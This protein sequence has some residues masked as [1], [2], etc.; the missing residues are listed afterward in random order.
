MSNNNDQIFQLSLT[1][2]AF[3]L[4]FILMFLLGTMIFLA[5]KEN[6]DLKADLRNLENFEKKKEDLDKV[7]KLVEE[8]L[9]D[10]N[11]RNPDEVIKNLV[12]SARAQEEIV[13][14][15]KL[16]NEQDAKITTLSEIQKAIDTT[17]GQG[18][19]ALVQE[20]I[21]KAL[22]L[23]KELKEQLQAR[24][25]K[26]EEI[27]LLEDIDRVAEQT[28]KLFVWLRTNYPW[29]SAREYST[30]D[31]ISDYVIANKHGDCGQLSLLFITLC[32]YNGIPARWQS[33]FML[34][35][36]G[37]NLHDWAEIY[38]E[39]IGWIPVD[40][41]FGL[42]AWGKNDD[43][44]LFFFGG[45]DAYHLTINNDFGRPLSPEK[46]HLRSETVDFQRGEVEWRGGNLY[47]D[48]W[49]YAFTVAPSPPSTH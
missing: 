13:K 33:G 20:R 35:P 40:S 31:H 19:G 17:K 18:D 9:V 30:I 49:D 16:I 4:V 47:F 14:L 37:K 3:I 32:R 11:V 23:S 26:P 38:F 8:A 15:K 42:Q 7:K 29:A 21:E 27:A 44:R 12:D 2:I 43:E 28:K 41:S 25:E 24:L 34:Y 5:N 46:M 1:E 45:Q 48:Q 6:Q 10:M 36:N 39:G 22:R